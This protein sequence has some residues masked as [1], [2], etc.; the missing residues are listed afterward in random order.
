MAQ[1]RRNH[2]AMVPS[3]VM[4]PAGT[5]IGEARRRAPTPTPRSELD[6]DVVR[7]HIAMLDDRG[8]TTS[9]INAVKATVRPGDIVLEIGTGTGV[10]AVAAAR[11]G[12][13]RVYAVEAANMAPWARRIFQ[14]SGVADHVTMVRGW[15][16]EVTLPERADVLI[17]ELIGD[18]PLGEGIIW[19]TRDARCRLLRRDARIVPSALSI[20]CYPVTIPPEVLERRVFGEDRLRRWREWYGANFSPLVEAWGGAGYV[21]FVDPR[22]ARD[23]ASLGPPAVVATFHLEAV[24]PPR[25]GCPRPLH[26][27]RR[28][29]LN[30]VL[31][32]CELFAQGRQFLSTAPSRVGDDNHWFT[33]LR[34]LNPPV[35]VAP[36]DRLEVDYRRSPRTGSPRCRVSIHPRGGGPATAI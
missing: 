13:R 35:A 34:I 12:A 19:T 3:P 22:E 18:D 5:A 29:T 31:F 26:V 21:D 36:G 17:A 8:R 9:F 16:D 10:L 1:R 30:G 6:A 7:Q 24:G 33:P 28:G 15:A 11:A 2:E 4:Q 14:A 27:A 20:S 25:I 32:F 23:W